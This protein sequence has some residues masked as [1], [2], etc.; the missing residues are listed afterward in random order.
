MLS[1]VDEGVANVS[2]A[3]KVAGM[4]DDTLVMRPAAR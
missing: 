3:L 1:A 4:F 2:A